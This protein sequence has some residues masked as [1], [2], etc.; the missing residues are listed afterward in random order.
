MEEIIYT[1][2]GLA[3]MCI[4]LLYPVPGPCGPCPDDGQ[5]QLSLWPV[6]LAHRQPQFGSLVG[7]DPIVVENLVNLVTLC[8]DLN[9]SRN[10]SMGP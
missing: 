4:K 6:P 8:E 2:W 10:M 7:V 9:C 5:S 3:M 1:L